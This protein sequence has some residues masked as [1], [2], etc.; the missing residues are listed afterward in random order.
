MPS[1]AARAKVNRSRSHIDAGDMG[2]V[3]KLLLEVLVACSVLPDKCA[4]R[5]V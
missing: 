1:G 2:C 5:S 4:M 3:N